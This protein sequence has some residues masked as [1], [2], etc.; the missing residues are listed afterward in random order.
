MFQLNYSLK[1]FNRQYCVCKKKKKNNKKIR[2]VVLTIVTPKSADF[3]RFI[4]LI[5]T[6][7]NNR[8]VIFKKITGLGISDFVD[9]KHAT[10]CI[11]LSIAI[12]RRC[13]PATNALK[14]RANSRNRVRCKFHRFAH[15][16]LKGAIPLTLDPIS[17][18]TESAFLPLP[19]HPPVEYR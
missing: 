12:D 16:R 18:P 14:A 4:Q 6:K 10:V 3:T 2:S 17:G 1:E 11:R 15:L 5:F 7:S 9:W 8:Y 13:Y 19:P